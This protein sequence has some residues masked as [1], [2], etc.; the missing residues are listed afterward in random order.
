LTYIRYKAVD[1][2]TIKNQK[3]PSYDVTKTDECLKKEENKFE[4]I[5]LFDVERRNHLAAVVEN[6]VKYAKYLVEEEV[7]AIKKN[8]YIFQFKGE[9]NKLIFFF[10][11]LFF[12]FFF[13]CLLNVEIKI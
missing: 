1:V 4:S 8:K 2:K 7:E 11:K 10:I 13:V 12:F 6:V 9:G 5:C 3:E